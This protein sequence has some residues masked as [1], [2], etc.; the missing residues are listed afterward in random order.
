MLV[1][2]QKD[3]SQGDLIVTSITDV[4]E[5]VFTDLN[6]MFSMHKISPFGLLTKAKGNGFSK[7]AD[8]QKLFVCLVS[9]C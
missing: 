8:F 4:K 6:I 2:P 1:L 7:D 9:L 5:K 3:I